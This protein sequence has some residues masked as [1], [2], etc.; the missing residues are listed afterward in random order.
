MIKHKLQFSSE[1]LEDLLGIPYQS[2]IGIKKDEENNT[3]EIIVQLPDEDVICQKTAMGDFIAIKDPNLINGNI[4]NSRIVYERTVY[5]GIAKRYTIK[6][7]P[8]EQI[9]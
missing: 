2:L 3:Y 9:I 4:Q 7:E 6:M 5:G 1:A 8:K